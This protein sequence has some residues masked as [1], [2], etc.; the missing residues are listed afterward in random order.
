MV[1]LLIVRTPHIV[2]YYE[3]SLR[4][5]ADR[6]H[7]IHIGFP[8]RITGGDHYLP[9]TQAYLPFIDKP[10][11]DREEVDE[12][13][14]E[15][16]SQLARD[17][18]N[19]SWGYLRQRRNDR[20]GGALRVIQLCR[21]YLRYFDEPFDTASALQENAR[22]RAPASFEALMRSRILR[23]RLGLALLRRFLRACQRAV[24]ASRS[25]VDEIVDIMPDV[26]L[27]SRLVDFGSPQDDY[28]RAAHR[29]GIPVGLPVASWDNL[30]NKGLVRVA[31]DFVTVWNE[32]QK[33][34]AIELHGMSADRVWVTGAQTFDVWF[35][36][37]PSVD[38]TEFCQKFGFSPDHKLIAYLGSSKSIAGN[39]VATVREWLTQ[40]RGQ[41][42]PI[43]RQSSVIVRPHPQNADQWELVDLSDLGAVAI[44]PRDGA[45]PTNDEKRADYFDT[46]FHS[47]A[48][49]GLNTSAQVEAAILG[50]PVLI[51]IGG[52]DSPVRRGTVETL[53]FRYLSDAEHGVASV[54]ETVADHFNQLRASL[55]RPDLE[56]GLQFVASFL[57]PL[58]LDRPAAPI[59]ADAIERGAAIRKRP[60]RGASPVALLLRVILYLLRPVLGRQQELAAHKLR[61]SKQQLGRR[62]QKEGAER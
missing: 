30:S 11:G 34:E 27:V 25:A 23:S 58:G 47:A 59:L 54:A 53:H 13:T 33:R 1:I 61:L 6:G 60:E 31:P 39:E 50:R 28:V 44:W 36:R 29:L 43:L 5:L 12:D 32:F 51:F 24:P 10:S 45:S 22:A 40:L 26:V 37:Q 14:V 21:D 55:R 16:L 48:T 9:W 18:P 38:R 3:S 15:L 42:D 49:V 17:H 57:R 20:W 52:S 35:D 8:F 7:L 41:E 2:R 46:L 62:S 56:R 4:I 19:F